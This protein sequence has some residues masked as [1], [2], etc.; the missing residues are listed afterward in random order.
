MDKKY[1]VALLQSGQTD[2]SS[3]D[4]STHQEG[5]S[6]EQIPALITAL[7]AHPAFTTGSYLKITQDI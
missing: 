6:R 7:L 2:V 4:T 3:T 1:S 5:I